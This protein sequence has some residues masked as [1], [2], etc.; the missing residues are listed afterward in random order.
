MN[1]TDNLGEMLR[2]L[3]PATTEVQ[4]QNASRSEEIWTSVVA[5]HDLD[6]RRAHPHRR[7]W[8]VGS[9]SLAA[10]GA[11]TALVVGLLGGSAPLSA[12][13]A[14]LASAAESD[15]SSAAL[16]PLA[17]GQYYYQRSSVS[18]ACTFASPSMA[19]SVNYIGEGTMESWT[20]ADG[21]GRVVVTPTAIAT[22]GSHFA[23]AQDQ[24]AWVAAGSPFIPCAVASDSNKLILNPANSNPGKYGGYSTTV[25]GYSGF[26]VILTSST[27]ARE[28]AAGT[29]V[30]NLPS[31]VSQI[32]SLLANGELNPNGTVASSPQVCPVDGS[33]TA[34]GCSAAQQLAIIE[35][36]LQVPD[37]SAKLGSV[38]YQVVAQM[39]GAVEVRSVTDQLGRSGTAITVP[40][41]QGETL[42]LVLDPTTGALLSLSAQ[43]AGQASPVAEMTY[44]AV[45]VVS[46]LGHVK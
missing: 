8:L 42:Q 43:I 10:A 5:Q 20:A 23:T 11:A 22:G 40:S 13:A 31:N 30:N 18:M 17:A 4:A 7:R 44:G 39:P 27:Q 2:A 37:A 24:A 33:G 29:G 9:G 16:P 32:A 26:G 28:V 12:A 38:L 3:D 41:G 34:T 46:G 21:S 35:Q 19:K 45:S 1:S 36:L 14:T 25:V 6:G 15:A